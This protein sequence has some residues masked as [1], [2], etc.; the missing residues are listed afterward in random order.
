MRDWSGH[1]ILGLRAAQ[2]LPEWEIDLLKPDMRAEVIGKSFMPEIRSTA[3]KL[4]AYCLIL[5]WIYQDEFRSYGIQRD[6]KWIPHGPASSDFTANGQISE[7]ANLILISNMMRNMIRALKTG[8]WEEAV[9]YAGVLGHFLQEPFTP[10]HSTDNTLF[11]EF[12]PDP[13]PTRHWRLHYCFDCACGDFPPPHPSLMGRSTEEAAFHLFDFIKH[14]ISSARALIKPVIEAAY[15]GKTMQE[16]EHVRKALLRPQSEMAS[17]I[18][19][20]AWH[21]AFCIA[22]DRF[23]PAESAACDVCDMTR[24][25]PYFWHPSYYAKLLPG[26]L[27]DSAG[28]KHPLDIWDAERKEMRCERGFALYGHAGV[29]FFVNGLFRKFRCGLGMPSRLTRGQTEHT[30]LCFKVETDSS[31][32]AVFSED[33]NYMA[34][35][36]VLEICLG[37]FEPLQRFELDISGA[38]TLI[39]S[40]RATPY[41]DRNGQMCFDVPDLV[42]VEPELLV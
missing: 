24:L 25:K 11:A 4:G 1:A 39:I 15:R 35:K 13:D 31:E 29:K 10:G 12:F 20:S 14:G 36:T 27:L 19:A 3:E 16:S 9:K 42:L 22:F 6:G 17:Y 23:D 8:N 2:G 40:S 30:K 28:R 18:T 38:K 26:V 41:C 37:A 21:T 32:N 7:T 33:I 5:D 34:E